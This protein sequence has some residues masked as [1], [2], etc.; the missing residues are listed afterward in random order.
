MEERAKLVK[1]CE[2]LAR[3]NAQITGHHNLRQRIQYHAA[4]K[5]ENNK[6]KEEIIHLESRLRHK[7][8]QVETLQRILSEKEFQPLA[9]KS[10]SGRRSATCG[11]LPDPGEVPAT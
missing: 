3:E 1:E 10:P 5:M 7:S 9:K 8:E 6:L 4:T 2:N 11:Q